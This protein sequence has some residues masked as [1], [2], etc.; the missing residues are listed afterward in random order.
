MAMP[1]RAVILRVAVAV[2][3]FQR[4]IVEIRVAGGG[5]RQNAGSGFEPHHRRVKCRRPDIGPDRRAGQV[6]DGGRLVGP[7]LP[8][9]SHAEGNLRT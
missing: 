3:V 6:P 8:D 7:G 1:G 2:F 5:E 9:K 4:S